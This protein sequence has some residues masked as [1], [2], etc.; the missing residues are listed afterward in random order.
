MGVFCLVEEIKGEEMRSSLL[1]VVPFPAFYS[2]ALIFSIT[3][4]TIEH[5]HNRLHT[6]SQLKRRYTSILSAVK[7]T[8]TNIPT[9]AH[10][11][12]TRLGT[13]MNTYS[14]QTHTHTHTHMHSSLKLQR[15]IPSRSHRETIRSELAGPSAAKRN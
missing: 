3:L 11:Q 7:S 1:K 14:A 13:N 6:D 12:T 15:N 9:H 10:T 2:S 5:T 4:I 8:L